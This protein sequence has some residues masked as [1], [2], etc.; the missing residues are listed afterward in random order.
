ML[1]STSVPECFEDSTSV[2]FSARYF[3]VTIWRCG[4]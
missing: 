3:Y 1:G 4:S 2:S